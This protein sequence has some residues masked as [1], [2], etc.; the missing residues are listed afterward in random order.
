[1]RA[2]GPLCIGTD[3]AGSVRLPAAYNGIFALKPSF[4]R[5]PAV[6]AWRASPARSHNGPIA[7]TVRD[8]ALLMNALAGPH[9]SD[10]DSA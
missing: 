5:I 2:I 8:A 9:P 3:S 10:P 1:M 4:Q 6:Q 7:R